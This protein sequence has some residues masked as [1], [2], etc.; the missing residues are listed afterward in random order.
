MWRRWSAT[1]RT[2]DAARAA[3]NDVGTGRREPHILVAEHYLNRPDIGSRL[4]QLCRKA[5]AERV[6]CLA[7]G[8]PLRAS[9]RD[10]GADRE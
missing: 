1:L 3:V 8:E 7:F 10:W 2:D 4:E 6:A 9:G 5:V